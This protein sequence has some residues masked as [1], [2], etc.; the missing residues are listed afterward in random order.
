MELNPI[1]APKVPTTSRTLVIVSLCVPCN[2]MMTLI[3]RMN[4]Y[5]GQLSGLFTAKYDSLH[6]M[7]SNFDRNRST[8]NCLQF[9]P[10]GKINWAHLFTFMSDN[11]NV[12]ETFGSPMTK[13][14]DNCRPV[15]DCYIINLRHLSPLPVWYT[16]P[17]VSEQGGLSGGS[18]GPFFGTHGG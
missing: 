6:D 5:H 16:S 4:T 14:Q 10:N 2:D 15:S 9:T 8:K 1:N 12:C 13:W 7:Y 18:K 11:N 17:G 3:E